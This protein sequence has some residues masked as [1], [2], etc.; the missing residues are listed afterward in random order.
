MPQTRRKRKT[1]HRGNAAGAIESRGRTGRKP[2][3]A[4]KSVK[5]R[6]AAQAKAAKVARYDRPPTWSGAIWRALAAAVMMLALSLALTKRPTTS[7]ILFPIVLLMYIPLSY[8]TD[9]WL[10]KRRMRK[11]GNSPGKT[12]SK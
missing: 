9:Q 2:T 1:K 4:E 3:S 6:E 8:Y 11:A 10:F 5:G 7:F 12:S